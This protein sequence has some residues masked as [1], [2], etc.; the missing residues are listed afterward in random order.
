MRRAPRSRRG[1]SRLTR[2]ASVACRSAQPTR[3]RANRGCNPRRRAAPTSALA[4]RLIRLAP[5]WS[6]EAR[7]DAACAS[8]PDD[9]GPGCMERAPCPAS[10]AR[11]HRTYAGQHETYERRTAGESEVRTSRCSDARPPPACELAATAVLA[12][13]GHVRLTRRVGREVS[14]GQGPEFDRESPIGGPALFLFFCARTLRDS[15]AGRN[16]APPRV[17]KARDF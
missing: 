17:G 1:R 7:H 8:A 10:N 5:R 2:L 15:I 4:E 9:G 11:L 3:R 12:A 6:V 13:W 14:Q 16:L